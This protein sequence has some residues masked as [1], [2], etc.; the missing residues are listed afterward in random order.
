ML[1]HTA[2]FIVVLWIFGGSVALQS[3]AM[4][5]SASGSQ[6]ASGDDSP[7]EANP[8]DRRLNELR[9]LNSYFPLKQVDS[10]EQWKERQ[11]RIQRR[12]LISQGLWPMP[13]KSPLHPVIHGRV[14]RDD[15]VVD[16]VYFESLPGHF[17]TG[18][19]YRPKNHS[20]PR[21]AILSP[22]G[23]WND[24]R[25]F[26]AGVEQARRDIADGGE[27][28][29]TAALHPIQARAVQLARMGCLVFVYDMT[30]YAD[31]VQLPHRP[32]NWKELDR[33]HDWGFMSVQADL[34]LQNMMGLQ[35]WNSIRAIDFLL[36]LPETDKDRLGVT[37]AS[38]G[39]TQSMIIGAIDP[40]IDAAMPCVMVSTAMQGGCTC[41]NAPLLRIDQGNVDIAAAIAPRPLGLTAADDWTV[42]LE[43][44]GFP[45]LKNLYEMLGHGD[46]L[47]AVFHTRF[48]HNYNYVNRQAMYAFFNRHFQLGLSEPITEREFQPL[49][50]EE[51]T[52]WSDEHPA[53]S[54]DQ[55]GPSHE[56]ELLGIATDD[57]EKKF[58]D[59][60]PQ[61]RSQLA[62]YRRVVG[63]AWKTILGR[64]LDQVG[65]VSLDHECRQVQETYERCTGQLR[66]DSAD[67]PER[68]DITTWT[69]TTEDGKGKKGWVIWITDAGRQELL[70]EEEPIPAVRELLK[71]GYSV[72]AADLLGQGATEEGPLGK[73]PMWYQGDGTQGWHRFSGYT[74]GY[75]HPLFVKRVHDVLTT[76]EYVRERTTSGGSSE[77]ATQVQLI[78]IGK[79]AGPIAAA[80]RSQAGDAV[81]QAWIGTD[82]FRFE[83]LTAHDD[84]MFVPGAV[85]Y[86]DVGGLIS[87]SAPATVHVFGL[88]QSE[89]PARVYE[90]AGAA[91]AISLVRSDA[92]TI[93]VV[94]QR[95]TD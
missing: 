48:G 85:K 41:E 47:S 82:G 51:A 86:G 36:G 78:G 44:K 3:P 74:Y 22:H 61:S 28:F 37:G 11:A 80:A 1:R 64:D 62:Q 84:P 33:Q 32:Q 68:V 52:V 9:T 72:L 13:S 12:I 57:A 54:G 39:G 67:Q 29:E 60:V 6:P 88:R 87:L 40:R 81:D 66:R 26:E 8:D 73:Q 63:G 2:C 17:V 89:L 23:H 18:S 35:T 27:P 59:L 14:E 50:R 95:L 42:E 4:A 43:T 75:N 16:R 15:Y 46:R 20:G 76:I 34:R 90:A 69:P 53:P 71:A 55:V 94:L 21:P 93:D 5:Q 31:S 58:H 25:F 83:S 65:P 49:S 30:G 38:G 92:A 77:S 24:G 7:S 79:I 10:P 19:L 70:K 56:A 45:E 91:E